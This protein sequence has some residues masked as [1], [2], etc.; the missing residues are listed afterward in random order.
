MGMA[1]DARR[2]GLGFSED[3]I[4]DLAMLEIGRSGTNKIGVKRVSKRKERIVGFDWL[5]V[6]LRS[7]R[8]PTFYVVQAKKLQLNL[9]PSYSYGRLKYPA[10]T[11]YQI[12]AL[13]AF[14]N[15]LGAV[16]MYCFYNNVDDFTAQTHWNCRVQQP[17]VPPQMG[18]TLAPLDVVRPVHDG[19]GPK[20]F[21]AIH[22][23]PEV[24]PWRCLFHPSCA[25]FSLDS[26]SGGQSE[27]NRSE[28]MNRMLEF[29]PELTSDDEDWIDMEELIRQLDLDELVRIYETGSFI[30]IPDR[31][32]YLNLED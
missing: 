16:P 26:K 17:P 11:N 12:D 9:S 19:T 5:W 22:W 31:V 6:I 23:H 10:G 2:L 29:L 27:A 30:P 15:W 8:F 28:G 25:S 18:C 1:A 32:F 20:N 14:A 21:R 13:E 4:S 3:T 7:G 24:V